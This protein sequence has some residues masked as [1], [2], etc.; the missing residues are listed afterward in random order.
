MN[1]RTPE[2]QREFDA[3]ARALAEQIVELLQQ[4]DNLSDGGVCI[5][6]GEISTP[7][8]SIMCPP[9]GER[10]WTLRPTR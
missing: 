6:P 7:A 2:E 3:K 5:P 10:R 9:W 8:G 1:S 4:L